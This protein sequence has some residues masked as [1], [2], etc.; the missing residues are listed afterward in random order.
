ML[1]QDKEETVTGVSK[2][3]KYTRS[4]KFGA[5]R[6]C[7]SRLFL[8]L[9]L[10]GPRDPL[11]GFGVNLSHF[12]PHNAAFVSKLFLSTL[13]NVASR[14]Y[15]R[16]SISRFDYSS[17][18]FSDRVLASGGASCPSCST[19]KPHNGP[20][21]SRPRLPSESRESALPRAS[22]C[23]NN[24]CRP[25]AKTILLRR[26]PEEGCAIPF[27]IQYLLQT[28]MEGSGADGHICERVSG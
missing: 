11:F 27:Y 2:C 9:F 13:F 5:K 4:W 15:Y 23:G 21:G 10:D 3:R 22:C 6:V 1:R 7:Q 20:R 25:M 19:A 8:P 18:G 14:S 26:G 12:L 28:E 16:Y 24:T 17:H